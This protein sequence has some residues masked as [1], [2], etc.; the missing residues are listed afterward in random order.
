MKY[1]M[2]A[3]V[4]EDDLATP[5]ATEDMP[6]DAIAWVDEMDGRGVRLRCSERAS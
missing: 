2:F 3:C 5:E 6:R 4:D 1:L